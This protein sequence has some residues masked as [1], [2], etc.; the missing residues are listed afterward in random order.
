MAVQGSLRVLVAW[1]GH[2]LT[3]TAQPGRTVT[4]GRDPE[5]DLVVPVPTVSRQHLRLLHTKGRWTV[6]DL[7]STVGTRRQGFLLRPREPVPLLHGD[8]LDLGAGVHAAVEIESL[9]SAA[10]AALDESADVGEARAVSQASTDGLLAHALAA[11]RAIGQVSTESDIWANAAR[12][13]VEATGLGVRGAAVVEVHEGQRIEVLAEHGAH[14]G[15]WSRRGIAEAIARPGQTAV[16]ERGGAGGGDRATMMHDSQY[17]ACHAAPVA[18]GASKVVLCAE[19]RTELGDGRANFTHFLGIVSEIAAQA[20]VQ[21]RRSRIARYVSPN[22]ASVLAQGASD[23]LDQPPHW[24]D[25]A[26]LFLDLQGFSTIVDT[27]E[28]NL[29]EVHSQMRAVMDSLAR[30]IFDQQ[31]MVV[32]FTGDGLFGAFG[33]PAA[34]EGSVG[35]AVRAGLAAHAV[36]PASRVGIDAGRC[37]FGPMGARQ[38]AKLGLFGTVVNRASRLESLARPERLHGGVLCTAAV[39]NEPSARASAQFLRIGLVVPAGLSEAV[40]VFEAVENGSLDASLVAEIEAASR[41]LEQA[42]GAS[43]L[44]AL[45]AQF[46]AAADRHRRLRWIAA[47]ARRLAESPDGW[48]G[49]H[50]PAK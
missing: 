3:L 4:L 21:L 42:R 41:S 32:D 19:G 2:S 8:Q 49:V 34:Q 35:A 18:L 38:H 11:S 17:L 43:A 7:G 31:G 26:C 14:T 24:M 15:G 36:A 9:G 10:I 28:R 22:L 47:Q 23:P 13:L 29:P 40:E 30:A 1:A 16:F 27:E 48:E 33:V 12:A 6:T 50:R 45:A 37:L 44:A 20:V 25:A 39:A 46:D 5:C